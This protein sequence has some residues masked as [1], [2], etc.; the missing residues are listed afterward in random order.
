MTL[1]PVGYDTISQSLI[2]GARD[3]GQVGRS[4]YSTVLRK[5]RR[6][7]PQVGAPDAPMPRRMAT[8]LQYSVMLIFISEG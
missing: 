5:A 6:R 4:T 1:D 3:G 7:R 8:M 2:A